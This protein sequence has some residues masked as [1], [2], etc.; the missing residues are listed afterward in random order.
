MSSGD[1]AKKVKERILRT[2]SGEESRIFCDLIIFSSLP[3]LNSDLC[4]LLCDDDFRESS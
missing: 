1:D 4:A 3:E 2:R